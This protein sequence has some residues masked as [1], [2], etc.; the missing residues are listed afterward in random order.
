[1]LEEN[2]LIQVRK[3]KLD[4]LRAMG[5]N[6]Y[7]QRYDVKDKAGEIHANFGEKTKEELEAE[8]VSVKAAGRIVAFRSFGKAAFSHIQ[9][10]TGKVQLYMKKDLLGEEQY[11]LMGLLDIGDHIGVEGFLFRTK[12][13]E[14]TIE[15]ERFTLLSKS[16][17]PLPEKWHGLTDVETRYRQRYVDLI[18]NPEVKK[19]FTTRNRI[20]K[21]IRAFLEGRRFLEVET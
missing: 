9:D 14:L 6:P 7:G 21:T 10:S 3:K 8:K 12:T 19:T 18:V 16:L 17:R 1:M 13:N 5:I 2:E 11:K 15:V 20:I 4:D